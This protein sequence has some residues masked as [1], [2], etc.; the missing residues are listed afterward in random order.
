[1][2]EGRLAEDRYEAYLRLR[3]E[4]AFET[5]KTDVRAALAEK[6]RNKKLSRAIRRMQEE[7]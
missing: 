2:E 7:E 5:R 6:Q 4:I 1:M 3:R